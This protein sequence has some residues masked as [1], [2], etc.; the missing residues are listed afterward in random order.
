MKDYD[1]NKIDYLLRES[2]SAIKANID[3]IFFGVLDYI[4]PDEKEDFLTNLKLE[5]D[6]LKTVIY[7]SI[8]EKANRIYA[9]NSSLIKKNNEL[10]K[11]K[12]SLSKKVV[13]GI[14][15]IK[16]TQSATIFALARLTESRDAETGGHLHRIRLYSQLL[17]I[18]LSKTSKYSSYITKEYIHNIYQSSP[19]HDIGKVGIQDKILLK[20][21]K[22]TEQEFEIMKTH[23]II[24]GKTLEDAENQLEFKHKSFLSMGKKIA[25]FHHERWDGTGYPMKLK[26]ENIPFSARIVAVADVYDALTNKRVYKKAFSHDEAKNIII[27]E[28]ETHFDPE[29]VE[30]FLN[31]EKR[32]S[33]ISG[34]GDLQNY[35]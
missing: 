2:I 18:E 33:Q 3:Q 20:P 10:N 35:I 17:A 11:L 12:N 19:L 26:G 34:S 9:L 1:E 30:V 24:G 31:L 7:D 28:T 8:I 25:Y 32:F 4:S 27:N 13:E 6:S 23:T 22:L 15:R 21:G 14:R 5:A 29:I 16:D